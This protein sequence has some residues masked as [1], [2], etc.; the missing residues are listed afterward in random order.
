MA[1]KS[2]L[3]PDKAQLLS[4]AENTNSATK[5]LQRNNLCPTTFIPASFPPP[6]EGFR[7]ERRRR[8]CLS[9]VG[10]GH[11]RGR[12]RNERVWGREDKPIPSNPI[13]RGSGAGPCAAAGELERFP[14]P[15]PAYPTPSDP[16]AG[17]RKARPAPPTSAPQTE[18]GEG[19]GSAA[20]G[21]LW[22]C[23]EKE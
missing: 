3:L 2:C 8:K 12:G 16:Q 22:F 10:A 1:N 17:K 19:W 21:G 6:D 20:P 23:G 9:F 11:G 5:G 14:F 4:L 15:T 13:A 7:G 18:G